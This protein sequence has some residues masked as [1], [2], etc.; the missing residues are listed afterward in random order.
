[1][2]NKYP[3][4]KILVFLLG[5]IVITVSGIL[6]QPYFKIDTGKIIFVAI[7][8]FLMYITVFLPVLLKSFSPQNAD[9]VFVGGAV[10]FI[11]MVVYLLVSII[12]I[13]GIINVLS[14]RIAVVVQL[15][16]VFVFSIY[17][18]TAC[19]TSD[20]I[21]DVNKSEGK[22]KN[23]VLILREKTSRLDSFAEGLKDENNKELK[24]SI[25][26]LSEDFRYLSPS[27][28]N[29]A[30]ELE[31]RM[32]VIVDDLLTDRYFTMSENMDKSLVEKKI[33]EL[34]VIFNQRKKIY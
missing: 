18:L 16:A 14:L 29:H 23:L 4:M 17:V 10:Y 30:V 21:K 19:Y 13:V 27:D 12:L 1:M 2:E 3:I 33:D 9:R 34:N 25:K 5:M 26:K 24:E 22:K 15:V 28:N 20:Y 8:V 7:S 31:Q 32:L 11:G 6:L